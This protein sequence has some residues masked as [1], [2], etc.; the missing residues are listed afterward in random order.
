MQSNLVNPCVA[1]LWNLE[2]PEGWQLTENRVLADRAESPGPPSAGTGAPGQALPCEGFPGS[3]NPN[4]KVPKTAVPEAATVKTET[5]YPPGEA[6][7]CALE[8]KALQG[9]ARC[10]RGYTMQEV[11]RTYEPAIHAT[12]C[13]IRIAHNRFEHSSSSAMRYEGND[14]LV[15]YNVIRDVVNESDDQGGIES[16]FNPTYRGIV[17]R[18]N[19]WS[20]IS[21]GT[22]SGATGVRMDDMICGVEVYGNI[23]ERCGSYT[24]GGVQING[25]KENVIENNIFYRCPAAVS[26]TSMWTPEKWE[27]YLDTVTVVRK[28]MYEDVDI[29]SA[30]Y[31]QRYPELQRLHE[32]FNRNIIR[33][34]LVVDCPQVLITGHDGNTENN[35][36]QVVSNNTEIRADGRGI[37]SL[38]QPDFLARYGLKPIPLDE[39]GP[40]GN[41]WIK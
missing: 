35:A 33:N 6:Q 5:G 28:M 10:V 15:E 11:K 14:I 9:L 4:A 29:N 16:Y 27:A 12:G 1:G 31:R 19:Y 41:P 17:V 22:F 37:R 30:V 7:R 36:R 26:F 25:G 24:F 32:D 20:D 38:C 18:Y 23:F 2:L 13:G 3:G 34:N 8:K 40:H 39:M 21:G